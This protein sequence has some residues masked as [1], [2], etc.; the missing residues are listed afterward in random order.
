MKKFILLINL[1]LA[2]D[3]NAQKISGYVLDSRTED[4]LIGAHVMSA[5]SWQI[6][7]T[8][9]I[10]GYFEFSLPDS[11]DDLKQIIVTYVGY[12]EKVISRDFSSELIVLLDPSSKQMEAVTVTESP[13][14]AEEFAME[15]IERLEVYKNPSAKGDALLAV[16][17][18]PSSTTLDESANIS[19]RGSSPAQ[20]G[21]FFNGVPVYDAVRFSQLNGIGTFSL[22]NTEILK[23]IQV[24]PGNP[25]LEFGNVSS[26]LI[27]I[28][29]SDEI[30]KASTTSLAVSLANLGVNHKRKIGKRSA[31]MIYSNYQPSEVL[32]GL[33]ERALDDIKSFESVDLGL[34]FVRNQEDGSKIKVFNYSLLEGYEVN[35]QSPT[36]N[37]IYDQSRRKNITIANYFKPLK[38]GVFEVNSGYTYTDMDFMFSR[39]DYNVR[40]HHVYSSINY[41]REKKRSGI[42]AGLTYDGAFQDFQGI[43]PAVEYAIGV[44]DPHMEVGSNTDRVLLEPYFSYKYIPSK[45][46]SFGY[47]L[48]TNLPVHNGPTYLSYQSNV[49]YDPKNDH[50]FKWSR[51]V[52]HQLDLPQQG[53][54]R[55]FYKSTQMSL[56]HNYSGKK[57]KNSNSLFYK[58]I[59]SGDQV[60]KI[61]GMESSLTWY[62]NS[63]S[64]LEVSYTG[65]EVESIKNEQEIK[66]PFDLNY[67]IRVAGEWALPRFWTI[68]FR[69][70]FR[71]GSYFSPLQSVSFDDQLEVFRPV[72]A[73]PADRE[74]LPSYNLV[75][76]NISKLVPVNEHMMMVFFASAANIFDFENVR[77]YTY[78]FDY[79]QRSRQLFSQ[80]TFYFG[81]QINFQ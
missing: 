36:F 20:T 72:F 81:V 77:D 61:Y 66:S 4:P 28:E 32:R 43:V 78:N 73:N 9:D 63:T 15:K 48:R 54:G 64:F 12:R 79:S 8:T 57:L 3:L 71:Q 19:F 70:L 31:L 21:I 35:F 45:I 52:Q 69:G 62:F 65:L 58:K 29:T 13:L 22:F 55:V 1:L 67:F 47:A 23:Q 37:G 11:V 26:G 75:D 60:D 74:R 14:F 56:D 41:Q 33:N 44:D 68:G 51:G 34:H 50:D 30:P 59:E 17:A 7:A 25:P 80:R 16:N 5:S 53:G 46:I 27:A 18:M 6:G 10:K 38:E 2:T 24:F 39:S 49:R 40:T 76:L 42:K